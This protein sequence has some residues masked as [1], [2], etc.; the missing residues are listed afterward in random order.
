MPP[1]ATPPYEAGDPEVSSWRASPDLARPSM[2]ALQGRLLLEW[3]SPGEAF[4]SP[5]S[6]EEDPL[7]TSS[8]EKG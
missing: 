3:G 4:R 8:T 6:P 7:K 2:T 5:S 1:P